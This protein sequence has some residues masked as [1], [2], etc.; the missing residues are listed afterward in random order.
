MGTLSDTLSAVKTVH[1][2]GPSGTNCEEAAKHW[3]RMRG[4][5]G[6]V[7]LHPTLETALESVTQRDDAAL[8]GCVVYPELHTLVFSNLHRLELEDQF[9]MPTL[10]MVLASLTGATPT[11]VS[12]HPAPR[13][14]VPAGADVRIV[15]SNAQAA[16]DCANGVTEGCITTIRAAERARLT[17]LKDFGAV[18]MGFTIH[19]P[20]KREGISAVAETSRTAG[21]AVA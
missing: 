11:T 16:L 6:E 4:I 8:L 20:K 2:L 19:R 10:N 17:V 5:D 13:Q 1:T 18:P 14:L 21:L 12:T 7:V 9:I 3:F 15:D